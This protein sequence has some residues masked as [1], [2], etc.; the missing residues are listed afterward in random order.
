MPNNEL[1]PLEGLENLSAD[2]LSN[3]MVA[4]YEIA[5]DFLERGYPPGCPKAAYY[6]NAANEVYKILVRKRD[7]DI[8][9]LEEEKRQ[10]KRS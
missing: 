5:D 4:L 2:E 9:D 6:R 1:P 3:K 7:K 8:N 10:R